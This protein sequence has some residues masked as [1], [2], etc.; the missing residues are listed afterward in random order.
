MKTKEISKLQSISNDQQQKINQIEQENSRLKDELIKLKAKIEELSHQEKKEFSQQ[1]NDF[2]IFDSSMIKDLEMID[3]IG[4]NNYRK[5]YKV[6]QKVTCALKVINN[7]NITREQ[8]Q[9]FI[10][11]HKTI[12]ALNHPNL[13]KSYGIILSNEEIPTSILAEY[14]PMNLND[15]IKNKTFSKVQRVCSIYEIA[16]G[17]KLLHFNRIIH[18]NIKPSNILISKNGQIKISDFGIFKLVSSDDDLQSSGIGTQKFMA[19]EIINEQS[20]NEKVDVYSFGVI[21]YFILTNGEMPKKTL[22]QIGT[23]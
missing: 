15:A 19:P 4:N 9:R 7:K 13:L 22:T 11:I 16:S 18:R 10:E 14:Y 2:Q 17:M 21:V 12:E 1:I 5:V 6:S 20:Y 23:G 3:E 8:F